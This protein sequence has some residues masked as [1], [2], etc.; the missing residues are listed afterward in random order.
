MNGKIPY[1]NIKAEVFFLRSTK[2][3]L[4]II[5]F[6]LIL[7]ISFSYISS[8][9][10]DCK[11]SENK[12]LTVAFS[13]FSGIFN[14]LYARSSSDISLCGI[15]NELLL[16]YDRAGEIVLKGKTGEVKS[17]N[18]I[19]YAYCGIADCT[20]QQNGEFVDYV[21]DLR[22]DVYF[23]DGVNLTA[24]DVIFTMYVMADPSYT[25][26]EQFYTLPIC[27]ME[28]YRLGVSSDS[29]EKYCSIADKIY[30]Y[31]RD[32]DVAD[33]YGFDENMSDTYWECFDKAWFDSLNLI[34]EYCSE[35]YPELLSE[36]N[37]NSTALGMYGWGFC[38][39]D[40]EGN[41]KGA[42]TGKTWSLKDGDIPDE[43]DFFEES[44]AFYSGDAEL[45]YNNALTNLS[46]ETVLEK[47]R[48]MFAESV[49]ENEACVNRYNS[50]SGITK[51]GKYSFTI[52]MTNSSVLNLYKLSFSVLPVHYYGDKSLFDC[53]K[54]MFGFEK[55]N[56][57][58]IK[59]LN[60][61]PVG[62]GPYVFKDYS[63]GVVQLT[64]NEKYY[65]GLPKTEN[66]SL[67]E[68]T[69]GDEI[70]SILTGNIDIATV[71]YD[72]TD[73]NKILT[74][75]SNGKLSG[76][77]IYSIETQIQSYGYV[78]INA[79][80][81]KVGDDASSYESKSLRKAFATLFSVYRDIAVSSFFYSDAGCMAEIIDY[82][83]PT[84][85]WASP[86]ATDSDYKQAF[87]YDKDGNY[88]Y[89]D[90]END[91]ERYAAA[92]DTAVDFLIEAG[93]VFDEELRVFTSA[94]EGASLKY[95][96]VI[97]GGGTKA[98]PGYIIA[99]MSSEA[100]KSVG[101]TL[102]IIDLTNTGS[103][104]NN[105]ADSEYDMWS[106]AWGR[107]ADPDLYQIYHSDSVPG[108]DGTEYNYYFI[109]DERLD[110][111]IETAAA[112]DINSYRKQLYK[113]CFD[114]ISDW[115]VEVPVFSSKTV[116]IFSADKINIS[117]VVKNSTSFWDWTKEIEKIEIK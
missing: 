44:T 77:K 96:I 36:F 60:S 80:R 39:L 68:V 106:A 103:I 42:S 12:I 100:L 41:L 51:N 48:N 73:I 74:V 50:I 89:K 49:S 97:P 82:P 37:N 16:D 28:E 35:Q 81:I 93:Y 63:D 112:S 75:N 102:E 3:P 84:S 98:H 87:S 31:G 95:T 55:G 114:I 61:K 33:V 70:N 26:V 4:R 20:I 17:Y 64:R 13:K 110:L 111:L 8:N 53:D 116:S 71:G 105:L 65:K 45:F 72:S 40:N 7:I 92:L 5:Q 104:W 38:E 83:I 11:N 85:S 2:N 62:A 69:S 107:G 99:S 10:K 52:K 14:P 88:I 67:C 27:G 58:K 47:A 109:E 115:G 78:G 9:S 46:N 32:Y 23:G 117:S 90:S 79:D 108:S 57:E 22:E 25:G 30:S 113:E 54:G 94:P 91:E 66:I 29:K 15:C 101:I 24:D 86:K 43:R 6:I 1:V 21:F 34:S 19:D 59:S 76:D 18:N 56:L